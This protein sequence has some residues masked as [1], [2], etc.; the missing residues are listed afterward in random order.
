ML[1]LCGKQSPLIRQTLESMRAAIL[2]HNGRTYS[3]I[4]NCTRGQNLA[5]RRRCDDSCCNVNA[6]TPYVLILQLNFSCVHAASNLDTEL[7]DSVANR[8]SATKMG[9]W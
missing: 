7:A 8:V 3:Q 9:R 5:W 6:D 4:F 2:E 1:R